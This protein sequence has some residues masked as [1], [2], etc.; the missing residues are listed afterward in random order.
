MSRS[1]VV[2]VQQCSPDSWFVVRSFTKSYTHCALP[3]CMHIDS[4]WHC[5]I[6]IT[7]QHVYT[8]TVSAWLHTKQ[9][10]CSTSTTLCH[11]H[12]KVPYTSSSNLLDYD[13]WA[14]RSLRLLWWLTSLE[15]QL[16]KQIMWQKLELKYVLEDGDKIKQI[17][18]TC[19]HRSE[20]DLTL[21]MEV[22]S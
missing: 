1:R 22:T 12:V 13:R 19:L 2:E 17:H 11:G 4:M 9:A 16:W 5:A 10:I 14:G 18:L 6:S 8:P 21:R 3:I 20:F 7:P 15:I